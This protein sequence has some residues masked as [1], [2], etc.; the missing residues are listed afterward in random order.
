MH[1]Q[2]HPTYILNQITESQKDLSQI[3]TA[4][5]QQIMASWG[6]SAY[7]QALA[8][9]KNSNVMYDET[10]MPS[11]EAQLARAKTEDIMDALRYGKPGEAEAMLG[12]QERNG[13]GALRWVKKKFGGKKGDVGEGDKKMKKKDARVVGDGAGARDGDGVIR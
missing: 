3:A 1:F 9:D 11:K 7:G 4:S 2:T 5:S 13:D 12:K 6:G 10:G 8:F